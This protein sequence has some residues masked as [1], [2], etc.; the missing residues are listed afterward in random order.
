[1][2]RDSKELVTSIAA[3]YNMEPTQILRIVHVNQEGLT[4]TVDDSLVRELPEGLDMIVEFCAI[5]APPAKREWDK[6]VD[7]VLDSEE[8]STEQNVVH[9]EGYELR[10]IF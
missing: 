1:M 2:R 7:S 4:I 10:L 3:K 6:P 5:T 8:T 9:S